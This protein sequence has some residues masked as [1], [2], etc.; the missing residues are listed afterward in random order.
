VTLHLRTPQGIRILTINFLTTR[1]HHF[2]DVFLPRHSTHLI[3][4][5]D[6]DLSYNWYLN[7]DCQTAMTLEDED[8]N[9]LIA[10]I[11]AC[12]SLFYIYLT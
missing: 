1:F 8:D 2:L 6:F 12:L 4:P 5:L 10:L 7:N 3:R 9:V 11:L